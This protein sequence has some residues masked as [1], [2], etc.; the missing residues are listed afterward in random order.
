MANNRI[1]RRAMVTCTCCGAAA[2]MLSSTSFVRAAEEHPRSNMTPDEA[3]R[4]LQEGN[5]K[6]ATDAPFRGVQKA[7]GGSRSRAGRPP[8]RCWSAAQ[9][10]AFHLSSCSAAAWASYS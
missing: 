8:L 6:F 2:G 3:L 10:A 7:S 4:L 1:S 9:T 5:K